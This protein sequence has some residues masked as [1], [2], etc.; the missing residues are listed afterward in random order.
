MPK[1]GKLF[2]T[3][4]HCTIWVLCILASFLV[5]S[6]AFSHS[7][8]GISMLVVILMIGSGWSFLKPYLSDND[9][10]IFVIVIPL[11]ILANIAVIVLEE[12][13]RG[14]SGWEAWVSTHS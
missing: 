12:N 1:D 13:M 9:K 8:R 6:H 5:I 2:T 10:K 4:F 11:Q 7:L 3:Y 14:F